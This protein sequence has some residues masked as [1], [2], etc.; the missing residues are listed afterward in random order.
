MLPLYVS[1]VPLSCINAAAYEYQIP[2]KL[3]ISV[4]NIERGKVGLISK[5]KNSSY[6]IGP[7][8]INSLWLVDLKR[9]GITQHDLQY[10]PCINVKVGTWILSKAIANGSNLLGGIGDYHSHTPVN[11]SSYS[12]KVKINFT[13]IK[14]LLQDGEEYGGNI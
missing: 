1:D 4:L 7:M 13:K 8:Q 10:D 3:I 11:N 14:T 12:Q 2:A 9:Y 5:N 6:D